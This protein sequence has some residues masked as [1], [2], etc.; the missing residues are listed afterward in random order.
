[1][2]YVIIMIAIKPLIFNNFYKPERLN[3]S[4]SLSLPAPLNKDTVSF[5]VRQCP[6][7]G[8]QKDL[9][10]LSENEIFSKIDAAIKPENFIGEGNEARVYKIPETDYVVRIVK[11]SD[12]PDN[13]NDYKTELS[14][15]LSDEDKINHVAAKLGNGSC[16]LHCLNGESCFKHK[17]KSDLFNL[18]VDSYH[19]LYKQI[20][21]AKDHDMIFDV[22]DS[23]IIYNPEDKSLTAI[24]FYKNTDDYPEN[25][26]P[27]AFIFCAIA[28]SVKGIYPETKK[29]F[30]GLVSAALKEL[31]SG[32]KCPQDVANLDINHLFASYE[33]YNHCELPPQLELLKS[34]VIDIQCL[35]LKEFLGQ[36][37]KKEIQGSMKVAKA[38]INQFLLKDDKSYW[39]NLPLN[40]EIY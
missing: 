16:I 15:D 26:K 27:L 9:L 25:V 39:N 30:G 38:L 14:F 23:N 24:D 12:K 21:F 20:S 33:S 13:F 7:Y 40:D 37:V 17:N 10:D 11:D 8:D 18:P 1:M 4:P 3:K 29:L 6:Q 31:E 22:C 28:Y 34:K 19:K 35:K 32:A 2:F 5:S 36:D